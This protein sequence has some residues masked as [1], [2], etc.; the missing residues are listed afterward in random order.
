MN[1]ALIDDIERETSQIRKYMYEFEKQK[2][3]TFSIDYFSSGEKFIESF[4]KYKYSVI[5]MDIF[6]DGL[7]GVEIAKM[8]RDIDTQC[9]IIFLTSSDLFMPQAFSCHAFEYIQKPAKR[10][11][12]F[13]VLSDI[14]QVVPNVQKHLEFTYNRKKFRVFYSEIVCV[15]ADKHNCDLTNINGTVFSPNIGFSKF[16]NP[17]TND[18]RFLLINR[19]VL[20]NMEYIIGFENN[21]CR[22]CGDI[23][24][25]VRIRERIKIEHIWQE[26]TFSKIHSKLTERRIPNDFS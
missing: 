5:F 24:L 12:I 1:I 23:N 14:L 17:L 7:N 16:I 22:L 20:V 25:P 11:R 21:I 8:I 15:V 26:Y 9:I 4:E 10:E 18:K 6:M 13:K 19:G 3:L 2:G